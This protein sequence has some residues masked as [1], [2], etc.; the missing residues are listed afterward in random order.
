MKRFCM[1]MLLIILSTIIFECE[2]KTLTSERH[3]IVEQDNIIKSSNQIF[4][5][6]DILQQHTIFK[7]RAT[8]QPRKNDD[9][10]AYEVKHV[11]H[12]EGLKVVLDRITRT[13]LRP[14]KVELP[15]KQTKHKG[16]GSLLHHIIV[17]RN[18]AP[19]K[20][21]LKQPQDDRET[22]SEDEK[23]ENEEQKHGG[24]TIRGHLKVGN[25][26][27]VL[28]GVALGVLLLI[29]VC[30]IIHYWRKTIFK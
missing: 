13:N 14:K 16:H 3:G 10:S 27:L 18:T 8:S 30:S 26:E 24:L 17:K 19:D 23:Q 11:E 1:N 2:L 21:P 15:S 7:G 22:A 5:D 4:V 9:R 28:T 12:S 25:T 29:V 6:R 20:Q